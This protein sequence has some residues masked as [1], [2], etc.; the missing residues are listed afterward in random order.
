MNLL[1]IVDILVKETKK[2]SKK[3]I[4]KEGG[5]LFDSR[6]ISD[7]EIQKYLQKIEIFCQRYEIDYNRLIQRVKSLSRYSRT[8]KDNAYKTAILALSKWDGGMAG[9]T[10]VDPRFLDQM[11]NAINSSIETQSSTVIFDGNKH[12]F[13]PDN[14]ISKNTLQTDEKIKIYRDKIMQMLSEL[15][16]I[17]GNTASNYLFY[18]ALEYM[19][20]AG[21]AQQI[22]LDTREGE[23]QA[24]LLMARQ[25]R[26]DQNFWQIFQSK[27]DEAK[28]RFLEDRQRR[29]RTG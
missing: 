16:N 15:Y 2:F 19:E 22:D 14:E 24:L 1:K 27:F 17:G 3:K 23:S 7:E 18:F 4:L 20:R 11:M 28:G 21:Y 12:V 9:Y 8:N 5:E 25:A 13:L 26:D 6:N 10:K 29:Q